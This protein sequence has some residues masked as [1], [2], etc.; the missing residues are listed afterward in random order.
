MYSADHDRERVAR[1]LEAAQPAAV[2]GEP[3]D[4]R[5]E[6]QVREHRSQPPN[7][8]PG[9]MRRIAEPELTGEHERHRRQEM[10]AAGSPGQQRILMVQDGA[11]RSGEIVREV[12]RLPRV[13]GR[14][15]PDGHP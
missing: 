9:Q 8:L 3:A 7:Q 6:R 2:T 1:V 12:E 14:Q 15:G 11:R 10:P 4:E 13:D 5:Y